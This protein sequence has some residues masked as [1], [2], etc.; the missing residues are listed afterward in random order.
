[1]PARVKIEVR[2]IREIVRK[3]KTDELAA[4]P[5]QDAMQQVEGMLSTAW[6]GAMPRASGQALS[7]ITTKVSAKP[8][9]TWVKVKTAATRSSRKYKRYRYMGRQEYDPKSR[10]KGRLTRATD[11]VRSRLQGVLD[12]AARK[13]EAGWRS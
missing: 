5:L 4:G 13:I 10:N 12:Q 2:G 6:R 7:K 1:M 8:V 3:L 9:P 11:G